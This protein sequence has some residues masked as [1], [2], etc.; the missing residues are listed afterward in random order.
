MFDKIQ[1]IGYLVADLDKAVAW[2]KQGFGAANAGGG[3]VQ[4]L[5][6]IHI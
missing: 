1:H 2:F 6:L 5:S 3:A 4:S